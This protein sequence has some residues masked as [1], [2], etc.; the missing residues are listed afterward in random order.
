MGS[1]ENSADDNQMAGRSATQMVQEKI[2]EMKDG[3][4]KDRKNGRRMGENSGKSAECQCANS[5]E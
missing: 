5:N 1:V 3:G 4:R 2:R